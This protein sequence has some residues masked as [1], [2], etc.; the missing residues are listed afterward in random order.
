MIHRHTTLQGSSGKVRPSGIL[1]AFRHPPV[2]HSGL[3]YGQLDLS[4]D[5]PV[6]AA[7]AI[8]TS[9]SGLRPSLIWSSYSARCALPGRELAVMTNAVH[10]SDRRLAEISYGR[11]EGRTWIDIEAEEPDALERWGCSWE[12]T[13]PPGGESAMELERRVRAWWFSLDAEQAH[14]LVAHAGVI[15]ALRVI[16]KNMIW[17]DAMVAP[18]PHLVAERFSLNSRS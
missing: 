16:S 17:S 4:I 13:G 18:V 7:Q 15:R 11:W 10:Y 5:D 2:R 8:R 12:T 14:I 6:G 9:I 1:V 3:C